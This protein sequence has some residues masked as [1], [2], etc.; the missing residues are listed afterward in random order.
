MDDLTRNVCVACEGGVSPLTREEAEEYHAQVPE[1]KIAEDGKSITRKYS[2]K[3]FKEA[4]AFVDKAGEVAEQEGHHP[5]I[6]FGW[7]YVTVLLTT[8]AIGGLSK[9]DFIV[10]AKTEALFS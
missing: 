7:G 2:F 3:D 8:H 4:L 5:D 10:A 6:T 9:N 1:W